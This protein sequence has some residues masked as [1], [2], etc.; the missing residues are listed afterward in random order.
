VIQDLFNYFAT[1]VTFVTVTHHR[2]G[3]SGKVRTCVR[4]LISHHVAAT[5]DSSE[6]MIPHF[7]PYNY[8]DLANGTNTPER[9]ACDTAIAP[10]QH[11]AW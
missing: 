1:F 8:F 6:S 2:D 4:Q 5:K 10:D 11:S 3:S 7:S 9:T